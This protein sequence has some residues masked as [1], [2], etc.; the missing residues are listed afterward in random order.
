MRG[1]RRLGKLM[2]DGLIGG[3]ERRARKKDEG[4]IRNMKKL[5]LGVAR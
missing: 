1:R 5:T 2:S 4:Q 3:E